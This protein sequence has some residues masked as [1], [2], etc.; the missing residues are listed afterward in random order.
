MASAMHFGS[1]GDLINDFLLC[2]KGY[3]HCVGLIRAMFSKDGPVG[4]VMAGGEH[5]FDIGNSL[6]P[7]L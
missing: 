7:R 2:A 1:F 4:F 6:N 3:P 5:L